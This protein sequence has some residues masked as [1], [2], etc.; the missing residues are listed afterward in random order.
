M[1]R[2]LNRG[3]LIAFAFAVGCGRVG[4]ELL[5]ADSNGSTAH[6]GGSAGSAG[7][8]SAGGTQSIVVDGGRGSGG[9]LEGGGGGG[10]GHL[11]DWSLQCPLRLGSV[12]ER[13]CLSQFVWLRRRLSRDRQLRKKHRVSFPGL[14]H[15]CGLHLRHE[16]LRHLSVRRLRLRFLI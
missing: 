7:T 9:L 10:G 4:Y 3:L 8:V 15:A 2:A 16:W 14:H 12:F 6:A 5:P 11:R 13:G 1:A